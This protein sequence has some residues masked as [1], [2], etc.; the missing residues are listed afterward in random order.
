MIQLTPQM[1]IV[2]ATSRPDSSSGGGSS[3]ETE[4]PLGGRVEACH[5]TAAVEEDDAIACAVEHSFQA[6]AFT[7]AQQVLSF[8]A[9]G[10]AVEATAALRADLHLDHGAHEHGSREVVQS[11]PAFDRPRPLLEKTPVRI[12]S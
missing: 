12:D 6:V 2:V 7:P 9:L 4:Q 8:A 3:R 10:Q 11:C 5:V 1:R